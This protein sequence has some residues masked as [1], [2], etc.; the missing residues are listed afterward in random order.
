M[1]Q[2]TKIK[3]FEDRQVR[4]TWS[5][6][7]EK[8]YFVVEDVVAILTDSKDP[9]QYINRLRQRDTELAKGW[10]QFVHT[11]T[12]ET[13][14]GKQRM[15]CA[16]LKGILRIIQSIP[17]P[18][19]EPFKR[20]LA[21]VGSE[22][23]EEIENPEIA[24]QRTRELYKLKGYPDDWIEKRMRSIAIREE[25]T[26][27]WKNHGVNEKIEYS[28]LTAE[29]SKATFG[30]TPSEYKKVKNLKSQNLRDHFNDL[31]LIF[32]MLGEASTTAI[33]RTQNPEGFVQNKQAA[34]Q[35]GKIAGD[36]RKA[37]ELKTGESV[38][39]ESNFLPPA[40]TKKKL[41]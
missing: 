7:E 29:I 21:Q 24:T 27:E 40:K 30:L 17:S 41:T 14:G 4:T 31:E 37:L 2:N 16:G 11:L 28:I 39:S 13:S 32:S 38:V 19:A 22:R 33:V 25:L 1:P 9:K 20:W 36:A 12:V 35:G 5:E 6:A 26:D 23:I 10:V 18:K 3:L 8:W 34:R 15:N